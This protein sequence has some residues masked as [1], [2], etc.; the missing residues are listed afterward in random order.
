MIKVFMMRVNWWQA[1]Q[2]PAGM[3][4][5]DRFALSRRNVETR[6]LDEENGFRVSICCGI[7]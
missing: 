1:H 6:F 7:G 5:A 3:A 2:M 4:A